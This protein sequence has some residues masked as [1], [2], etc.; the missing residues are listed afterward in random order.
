MWVLEGHLLMAELG[1]EFFLLGLM[2][3]GPQAFPRRSVQGKARPLLGM[4]SLPGKA[5]FPYLV[6]LQFFLPYPPPTLS[7]C[8][9]LC[10]GVQMRVHVWDERVRIYSVIPAGIYLH[11]QLLAWSLARGKCSANVWWT[12]T[13]VSEHL[14]RFQIVALSHSRTAG[15]WAFGW[16]TADPTHFLAQRLLNTRFKNWEA[17]SLESTGPQRFWWQVSLIAT[18]CTLASAG[19]FWDVRAS[20]KETNVLM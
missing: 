17:L 6:L 11:L 16:E 15:G 3:A 10:V 1:T 13:W 9:S 8:L 12:H 5:G 2:I 7:F 18:D 19:S 14:A 20:P 4:L